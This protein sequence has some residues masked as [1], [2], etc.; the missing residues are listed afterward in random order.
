M[1]A[2]AESAISGVFYGVLSF[3]GGLY[4]AKQQ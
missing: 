1:K 4:K 3:T 2:A